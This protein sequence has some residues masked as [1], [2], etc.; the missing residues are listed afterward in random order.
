PLG[1]DH[2]F[3]DQFA[4]VVE[5]GDGNRCGVHI[6]ADVFGT[7]HRGRSFLSEMWKRSKGT[8]KGRSSLLAKKFRNT[9]LAERFFEGGMISRTWGNR[10]PRSS[11]GSPGEVGR[12]VKGARR[13]FIST[14]DAP[15]DLLR[16]ERGDEAKRSAVELRSL[17]VGFRCC[18]KGSPDLMKITGRPSILPS[19]TPEEPNALLHQ[20]PQM[21][22]PAHC[23]HASRAPLASPKVTS[24]V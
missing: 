21:R 22:K 16:I 2:R 10:C 11:A 5:D 19:K 14:L 24:P 12:G 6:H 15:P 8:T 3:H 13:A 7:I 17:A 23:L 4:F 1:L 20:A 18:I 9:E